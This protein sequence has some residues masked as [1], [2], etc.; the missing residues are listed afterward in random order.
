MGNDLWIFMTLGLLG[1]F[2]LEVLL[3]HPL[4][5]KSQSF[6]SPEL[7]DINLAGEVRFISEVDGNKM[8]L[9]EG[10]CL[11]EFGVWYLI[12]VGFTPIAGTEIAITYLEGESL[13]IVPVKEHHKKG[14][15][16][17]FGIESGPREVSFDLIKRNNSP[18]AFC[19][20]K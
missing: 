1:I 18:G 2:C 19:I 3:R 10:P 15:S 13:Y 11:F 16:S 20:P 17:P 8:L 9:M 7:I 4:N 14:S 6:F 5:R 12:P